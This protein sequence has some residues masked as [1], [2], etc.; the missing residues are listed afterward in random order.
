MSRAADADMRAMCKIFAEEEAKARAEALR[1]IGLF[2]EETARQVAE[3]APIEGVS[4]LLDFAETQ[5]ED[6]DGILAFLRAAFKVLGEPDSEDRL[7]SV[8]R[9]DY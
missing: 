9:G 7:L 3:V 2:R 8:L 5:F 1:R 6:D 4:L